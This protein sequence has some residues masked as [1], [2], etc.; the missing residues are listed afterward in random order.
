MGNNPV[1]YSD[2][3]GEK[4]Y[5][6]F[7]QECRDRAYSSTQRCK[8]IC[9]AIITA[10]AVVSS[11]GCLALGPAYRICTKPIGAAYTAARKVTNSLCEGEKEKVLP[12]CGPY[13]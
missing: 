11:A 5:D 3:L 4:S 7:A 9:T 12:T 8:N 10:G 2:P 1:Y 6:M 13:R